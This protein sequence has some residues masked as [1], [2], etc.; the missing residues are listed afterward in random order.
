MRSS[1]RLFLLGFG[2][3]LLAG[4]MF[5]AVG[6]APLPWMTLVGEVSLV[7][8][9]LAFIVGTILRVRGH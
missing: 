3:L 5:T 9:P 6:G 8:W 2:M 7:A 4:H 1:S